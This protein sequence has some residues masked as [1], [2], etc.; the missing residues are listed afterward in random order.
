MIINNP[1]KMTKKIFFFILFLTELTGYCQKISG[2]VTNGKTHQP[3]PYAH[4]YVKSNKLIG[5]TTNNE[6]I[7]S[8]VLPE[9]YS[10]DSIVISFIGYKSKLISIKLIQYWKNISIN[11]EESPN[12]L[13][14]VVVFANDTLNGFLKKVFNKIADNY[15]KK[16]FLI[17][18]CYRETN[19]LHP[20]NRFIYFSEAKIEFFSPSY[21]NTISKYG[22]VRI[23]EGGKVEVENRYLYSDIHFYA[24][25][26]SPQ[27]FDF[28]REEFEFIKPSKFDKYEYKVERFFEFEGRPTIAITFK[29]KKDALYSGK[30]FIDKA[31]LAYV[32]CDFELSKAGIRKENALTLSSFKYKSRE[33]VVQ[34]RF[35]KDGRWHLW[36]AIQDGMGAN[37]KYKDDLRYTNEFVSLDEVQVDTNPIP[38]SEAVNFYSFYTSQENKFND[39]YWR[40]PE[41]IARSAK[42][43]STIKLLFS[44]PLTKNQLAK[45]DSTISKNKKGNFKSNFLKVGAKLSTGI[46]VAFVPLNQKIGNYSLSSPNFL[47][48][49]KEVD[50]ISKA[51]LGIDIKYYLNGSY[52]LIVQGYGNLNSKSSLS[53]ASLG[54]Q[55]SK[56]LVGWKRPFYFEPGLHFYYSA[57]EVN[58]GSTFAT[59]TIS[60]SG[61]TF[62]TNEKILLSSGQENWGLSISAELIY[63]FHSRFTLFAKASGSLTIDKND[64]LN[65]SK[66]AQS[67]FGSNQALN[68]G[69]KSN[70]AILLIDNKMV[71]KS[72]IGYND[73]QFIVNT[74]LRFGLI[75]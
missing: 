59:N 56:R 49:S 20:N 68:F 60:G 73:I 6:G 2:V 16:N 67:F 10:G 51:A 7:F 71:E 22:P 39:N 48:T 72:P 45:T 64:Y 5:T 29:P 55:V 70:D 36:F 9:K 34:Y 15:P 33:Y 38:D 52:C 11:L 66:N 27:R 21:T 53:M 46:S 40:K 26:Y 32:K 30:L 25:L 12:E 74:G 19:L 61:I 63:K 69:L 41:T 37:S 24:G 18:G 35:G 3:L 62:N 75:R 43:D 65:L 42:S 44:N 58:L 23:I 47:S 4:V 31:T 50:E 1:K 57:S 13:K 8:L 14:E 54:F 28:V 17:K